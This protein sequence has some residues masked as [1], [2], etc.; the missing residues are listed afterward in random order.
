MNLCTLTVCDAVSIRIAVKHYV[1]GYSVTDLK[2]SLKLFM[3][4][5]STVLSEIEDVQSEFSV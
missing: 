1:N 3:A 5:D 2:T 4:A